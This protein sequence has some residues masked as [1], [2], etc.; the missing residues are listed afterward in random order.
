MSD[1]HFEFHRDAGQSFVEGLPVLGDAVVLAGDVATVT[2]LARAVRLFCQKFPKVLM[3]YGNHEFYGSD[4]QTVL[5]LFKQIS[6]DNPNFT[7]LD[8]SIAEVNGV[9]IVGSS[10]WFGLN[11]RA[12]KHLMNDF[13][14][15]RGFEG[16]VYEENRR[17]K[18]FLQTSIKKGDVVVTHYLPSYKSVHPEYQGSDLNPFFVCDVED[19]ILGT[20]PSYWIHGHTHESVSYA[21]G[22]TKVV[23]NPFG[24]LNYETNPSFL[25]DLVIEVPTPVP[26]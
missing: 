14:L 10:L 11:K 1:V 4:R 16:W 24:Y 12:P 5:D 8:N 3:V 18:A 17:A 20:S 25:Q 7:L 21:Y 13:K 19:I 26:A 9:S 15:I 22:E 2:G 6:A 23:C